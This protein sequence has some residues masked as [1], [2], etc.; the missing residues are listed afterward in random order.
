MTAHKAKSQI[1]GHHSF[2]LDLSSNCESAWQTKSQYPNARVRPN[3][4][5]QGLSRS[6]KKSEMWGLAFW[7]KK[8]QNSRAT[9]K[10]R[11]SRGVRKQKD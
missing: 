8:P 5:P 4:L 2:L 9:G 6:N 7:Q 10:K 11:V 1:L 3:D